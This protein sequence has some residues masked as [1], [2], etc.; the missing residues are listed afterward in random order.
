MKVVADL[1][2]SQDG[3]ARQALVEAAVVAFSGGPEAQGVVDDDP[4]DV[5]A[6]RASRL[7]ST[8]T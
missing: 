3:Q 1:G 2:V 4:R 6:G 5:H 8:S 7:V